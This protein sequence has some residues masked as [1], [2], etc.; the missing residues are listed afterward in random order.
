MSTQKKLSLLLYV[1]LG[2]MGLIA[3]TGAGSVIIIRS[4]ILHLARETSPAQV[5]LAELQ[6]GFEH[7][8]AL[9]ARMAAASTTEE[10]SSTQTEFTATVASVETTSNDLARMTLSEGTA[11]VI[12]KMAAT[13]AELGDI[14]AQRLQAREHMAEGNRKV[15]IELAS[16][17]RATCTFSDSMKGVQ[18]TSQDVLASSRNTSLTANANIKAMLEVR[19]KIEELR[20]IVQEV[21]GIEKKFRLNPLRDKAKG[22][23]DSLDA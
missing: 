18:Q 13:G 22:E 16:V 10:L 17:E 4:Q 2:G 3:V 7:I 11:E 8:S 5:K 1:L 14:A 20:S 23:L 6:Q 15:G 12:H 21:R 9:F 19:A